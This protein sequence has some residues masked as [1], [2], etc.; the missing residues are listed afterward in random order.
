MTSQYNAP[1]QA[2]KTVII[3]GI[4]GGIGSALAQKFA[5]EGF[6]IGG[7]YFSN[8]EAAAA[9]KVKLEKFNVSAEIY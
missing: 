1:A 6:N 8:T 2:G 9:L 5:S 3:T 4:T 7:S